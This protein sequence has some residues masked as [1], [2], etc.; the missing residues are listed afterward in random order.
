METEQEKQFLEKLYSAAKVFKEK[1]IGRTFLFVFNNMGIEVIFKRCN[2]PHLCGV[3]SHLHKD[4]FF[5]RCLNQ[6]LKYN[7]ITFKGLVILLKKAKHNSLLMQCYQ[8]LILQ[9]Y[10]IRLILKIRISI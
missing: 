10:M 7:E 2:F 1:M 5:R 3:N 8:D 4:V 9:K 6:T